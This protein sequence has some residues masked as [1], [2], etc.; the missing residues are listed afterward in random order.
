MVETI[1]NGSFYVNTY[2]I[3]KGNECVIIDPGMGLY[4]D[5]II[6][7]YNV[8]GILITHAHIDHIDGIKHF[9]NV[10]IYISHLDRLKLNNREESLYRMVGLNIPFD[11]NDLNI[12]EVNDNDIINL[13]DSEIKVIAT[14][15][16]TD[17]SVCYLYKNIL[18]SGD[19][20]FS[21]S[22][23]RTD[24]PTGSIKMMK[25][26]LAKLSHLSNQIKVYPGHDLKTTIKDEKENNP[27]LKRS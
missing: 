15:G 13:L 18:F 3:I 8:I 6:N 1:V 22:I 14:P 5:D 9:L 27:Y 23:G 25:E 21:N 12:I 16:H 20:L 2:L 17:G 10:P 7:K 24:F 19:T 11:S 26:S 4:A